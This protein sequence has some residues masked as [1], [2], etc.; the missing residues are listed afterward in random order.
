MTPGEIQ[1]ILTS[2][3]K[4]W[5]DISSSK[6]A[7]SFRIVA[8]ASIRI[9]SRNVFILQATAMHSFQVYHYV[10]YISIASNV[11]NIIECSSSNSL[12]VMLFKLLKNFSFADAKNISVLFKTCMYMNIHVPKCI[13]HARKCV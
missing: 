8:T 4:Y 1:P 3:K 12:Y 2:C 11:Q 10:S 13:L 7:Q 9:H 6:L 5:H